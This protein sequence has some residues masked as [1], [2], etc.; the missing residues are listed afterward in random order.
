MTKQKLAKVAEAVLLS[1]FCLVAI[2]ITL[3]STVFIGTPPVVTHS[4]NVMADRFMDLR[5][6][7]KKNAGV[8]RK[9]IPPEDAVACASNR[10]GTD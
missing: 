5:T 3:V 4:M 8:D 10:N 2:Y 1:L 6:Y 9:V 7:M